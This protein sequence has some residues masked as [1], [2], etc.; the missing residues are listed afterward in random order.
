MIKFEEDGIIK[1]KA[2]F[3]NCVVRRDG[4]DLLL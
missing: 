2:C 1:P 4:V 3:S